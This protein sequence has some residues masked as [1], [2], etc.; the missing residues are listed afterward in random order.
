MQLPLQILFVPGH[1]NRFQLTFVRSRW[2]VLKSVQLSLASGDVDGKVARAIEGDRKRLTT[3][4]G[5]N[6]GPGGSTLG[7]LPPG[8]PLASRRG[9]MN[10]GME[11]E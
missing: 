1:L 8:G 10:D 2:V 9:I 3:L 11:I 6:R 5:K 7:F 4:A